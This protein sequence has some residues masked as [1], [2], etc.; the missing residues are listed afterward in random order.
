VNQTQFEL[1]RLEDL[2]S[3]KPPPNCRRIHIPINGQ[4]LSPGEGFQ[5]RQFGN[6]PGVKNHLYIFEQPIHQPGQLRCGLGEMGI[7][8]DADFHHLSFIFVLRS[9]AP[10]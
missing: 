3:G 5:D 8:N 6:I 4:D 10:L 7:G 2:V 1:S 9:T